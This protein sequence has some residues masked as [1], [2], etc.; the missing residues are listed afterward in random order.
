MNPSLFCTSEDSDSDFSI[1]A[2]VELELEVGTFT[3]HT[4]TVINVHSLLCILLL[5]ICHDTRHDGPWGNSIG[6][7]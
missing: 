3:L 6:S 2:F 7:L 1:P 5:C 4:R